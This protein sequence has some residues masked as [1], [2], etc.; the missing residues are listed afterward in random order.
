[1][2]SSPPPRDGHDGSHVGVRSARSSRP[3]AR[4][5]TVRLLNW[6]PPGQVRRETRPSRR[7]GGG[8]PIA[9]FLLQT[10]L[11][12]GFGRSARPANVPASD[13]LAAPG[14][15]QTQPS[16]IWAVV[17]L[18]RLDRWQQPFEVR[19]GN[20]VF[21]VRRTGSLSMS[22]CGLISTSYHVAVR[23]RRG[24]RRGRG[25]NRGSLLYV[26]NGARTMT[27][28]YNPMTC[29]ERPRKPPGGCPKDEPST[30][31]AKAGAVEQRQH[32]DPSDRS[33]APNSEVFSSQQQLR[34][35]PRP[36]GEIPRGAFAT[37]GLA[38]DDSPS[39]SARRRRDCGSR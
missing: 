37:S 24:D 36:P 17:P 4:R 16:Y 39:G 20:G 19:G 12:R 25:R 26:R 31:P 29:D 13:H 30:N 34:G 5:A 11:R 1:M 18:S 38:G 15:L 32:V 6:P 3:A 33:L 2:R 7:A 27:C 21:G 28:T 8:R 10:R 23:V 14:M 22:R 35:G 9:A